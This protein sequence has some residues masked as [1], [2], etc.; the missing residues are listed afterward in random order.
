VR[1][2]ER[3]VESDVETLRSRVDSVTVQV[4]DAR[5][6]LEGVS[7]IQARLRPLTVQLTSLKS[8]IEKGEVTPPRLSS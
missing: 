3:D 4:I 6:K 1:D 2:A 8:Q 7:A 5:R